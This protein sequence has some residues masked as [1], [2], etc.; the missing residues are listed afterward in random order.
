MIQCA[1][2][3]IDSYVPLANLTARIVRGGIVLTWGRSEHLDW[4][5]DAVL[6][7][8]G[9]EP[10]VYLAGFDRSSGVIGYAFVDLAV[11]DGAIYRYVIERRF[12]DDFL[13]VSPEPLESMRSQVI[14]I[15]YRPMGTLISGSHP[16]LGEWFQTSTGIQIA[17]VSYFVPSIVLPGVNFT[18][19]ERAE[20]AEEMIRRWQAW[21]SVRSL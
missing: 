6:R 8:S 16:Q 5:Y 1:D 7:A 20:I 18:P 13:R 10:L 17:D 3:N 19:T 15:A 14:T 2:G 21:A 12:R 4:H 9:E 11:T